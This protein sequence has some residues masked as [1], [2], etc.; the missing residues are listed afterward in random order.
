MKDLTSGNFTLFSNTGNPD[1]DGNFDLTW[2]ASSGAN[3]YSVYRHFGYISEINGSLNL[4]AGEIIDLTLGLE[5]YPSGTYYFIV[6]AHNNYGDTLS[7]C[8]SITVLKDRVLPGIPGYDLVLV[9]AAL[10]VTLIFL[11]KRVGQKA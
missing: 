6:V 8:I 10:S 11:I 5:H 9:V 7:N 1:N 2:I 3:N 4:L